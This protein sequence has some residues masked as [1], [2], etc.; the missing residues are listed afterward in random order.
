MQTGSL[1]P[2]PARNAEESWEDNAG[3]NDLQSL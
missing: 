1:G 3:R 2:F